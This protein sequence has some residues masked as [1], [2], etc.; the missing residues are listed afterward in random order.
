MHKYRLE[1]NPPQYVEIPENV[2]AKEF[3]DS[4]YPNTPYVHIAN[5]ELL[6][7]EDLS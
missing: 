7:Y 4:H 5:V 3:F 1:T 6:R 2:N